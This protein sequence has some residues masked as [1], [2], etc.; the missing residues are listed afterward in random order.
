MNK[1]WTKDKIELLDKLGDEEAIRRGY[2]DFD[3]WFR[4]VPS[5]ETFD[6][7]FPIKE[8]IIYGK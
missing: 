1:N 4:S 2:I 8:K 6:W 7:A 3:D 5:K